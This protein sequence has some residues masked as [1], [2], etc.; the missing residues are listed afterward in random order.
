MLSLGK[1][2][3]RTKQRH[4]RHVDFEKRA[5]ARNFTT[6]TTRAIYRTTDTIP[7]EWAYCFFGE[8][9]DASSDTWT[10]FLRRTRVDSA[11]VYN[12][13]LRNTVAARRRAGNDSYGSR[14]LS[15]AKIDRSTL[16]FVN[17]FFHTRVCDE[18]SG[19]KIKN[20]TKNGV[21]QFGFS[22]RRGRSSEIVFT[23]TN[24]FSGKS[25]AMRDLCFL[26]FAPKRISLTCLTLA[27]A[28]TLSA[29]L[30]SQHVQ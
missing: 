24:F 28:R 3:A 23:K 8:A 9:C 5:G 6:T 10:G 17:F 20:F 7:H 21:D 1:N 12:H 11:P 26:S 13:H 27:T 2:N 29:F 25:N 16:F 18:C 30:S 14:Y 4:H 19:I 22:V 15:E